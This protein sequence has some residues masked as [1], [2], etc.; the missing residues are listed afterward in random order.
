MSGVLLFAHPYKGSSELAQSWEL[1][2]STV[3]VARGKERKLR[4]AVIFSAGSE[5]RLPGRAGA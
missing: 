1:L 5:I 4:F 3:E 2:E